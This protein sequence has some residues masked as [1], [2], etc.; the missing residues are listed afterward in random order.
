MKH[1]KKQNRLKRTKETLTE[2]KK[3]FNKESKNFI[4]IDIN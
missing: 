2:R 1:R 4:K 3:E